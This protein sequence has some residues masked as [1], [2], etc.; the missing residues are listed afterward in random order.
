MSCGLLERTM[1]D[2]PG[3]SFDGADKFCVLD[4]MGEG[5]QIVMI[6]VI[7]GKYILESYP[8]KSIAAQKLTPN[9]LIKNWQTNVTFV[10][11]N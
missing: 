8:F 5:I 6:P 7:I 4:V 10:Y 2:K 1:D 11:Q 9:M 3:D